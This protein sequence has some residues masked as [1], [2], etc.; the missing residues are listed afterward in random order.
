MNHILLKQITKLS[1]FFGALCGLITLIPFINTLSLTFLICF[2][3]PF[4]ISILIKY[5][6]LS[7]NSIKESVIYGAIIGFVSFLSFCI[8]YM[9]IS[10]IL[11]KAF[12]ISTNYGVGIILLNANFFLLTVISIFLAILGATMNA[13]TGFLTFY[14]I[15]FL[16]SIT[17]K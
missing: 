10:F 8:I 16:N 14:I 4:V 15:D 13:F 1:L 12:N 17:K 9:P 5:N 11:I 7:L 3:A 2:M 6:C